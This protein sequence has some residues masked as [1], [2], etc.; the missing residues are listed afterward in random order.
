MS[1]LGRKILYLSDTYE[2]SVHDKKI[3]DEDPFDFKQEIELFQDLGF[4]GHAPKNAIIQMP[5]KQSKYKKLTAEVKQE[6]K[7]KSSKRVRVEHAICGIK[8][9]SIVKDKFRYRQYGYDDLVMELACGL[10]NFRTE[11]RKIIET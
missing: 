5:V 11:N 7:I 4:Q 1:N 8:R 2:G 3:C 9:C 10:H 6:K